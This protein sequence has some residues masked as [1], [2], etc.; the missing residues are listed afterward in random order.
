MCDFVAKDKTYGSKMDLNLLKI[1]LS[2][3]KDIQ[4]RGRKIDAIRL[5]GNREG[6]LYADIGKAVD[7]T[8]KAGF[9]PMLVTNGVLCNAEKSEELLKNGLRTINFSVSGITSKTYKRFQGYKRSEKQLDRVIENVCEFIRI[10]NR[11]GSYCEVRISMLMDKELSINADEYRRAINFWREMG[12]NSI[13]IGNEYPE[14]IRKRAVGSLSCATVPVID[15]DGTVYPCCGGSEHIKIGNILEDSASNVFNG[16]RVKELLSAI[17][18]GTGLPVYCEE[19]VYNGMP[20]RKTNTFFIDFKTNSNL[21]TMSSSKLRDISYEKDIYLFGISNLT[22]Y[23]IQDLNEKRIAVSGVLDTNRK[24][25]GGKMYSLPIYYPEEI[26]GQRSIILLCNH[27]ITEGL[28]LLSGIEADK[29]C[30]GF[31]LEEYS[32]RYPVF[33]NLYVFS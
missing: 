22:Q 18:S 8:S 29:F 9:Y 30:Y 5:D 19:C 16:I 32:K 12:V 3:L 26:D 4:Y 24:M 13:L 21:I 25:H 15:T 6:L 11:L 14:V 28:N 7:M 20:E 27:K 1:I 17:E 31:F 2:K 10:N 33:S 23:A